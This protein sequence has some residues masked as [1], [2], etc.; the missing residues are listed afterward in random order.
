MFREIGSQ[1]LF[2]SEIQIMKMKIAVLYE[3]KEL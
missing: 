1:D 2:N 3:L